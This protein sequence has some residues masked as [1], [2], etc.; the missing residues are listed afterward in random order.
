MVKKIN[1]APTSPTN[2]VLSEKIDVDPGHRL[3]ALAKYV[4]DLL[5]LPASGLKKYLDHAECYDG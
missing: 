2:F 5:D 3:L 4:P 1:L